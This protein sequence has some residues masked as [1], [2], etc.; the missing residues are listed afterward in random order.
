MPTKIRRFDDSDLSILVKL[1]ND[2]RKGSYQFVPL[3]EE[4]FCSWVQDGKLEILVVEKNERIVGSAAYADG[5]WGE[6]IEWFIIDKTVVDREIEERLV[7]KIEGFVKR[8]T[9]FAAVDTGS[10]QI[11]DWVRRGYKLEGG[12]CHMI[13]RL[14]GL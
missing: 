14:E 12:L 3:T 10:V 8:G 7:T 9:V 5:Y 11:D 6:E 13:A 1:L 2:S 4:G